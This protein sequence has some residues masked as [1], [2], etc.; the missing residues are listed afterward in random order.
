MPFDLTTRTLLEHYTANPPRT[1][2]VWYGPWISILTTLFPP[3][4]GYFV[5]P[6]RRVAEDSQVHIPDLLIEVAKISSPPLILRTVLIVKVRNSQHWE[7]G[8]DVL[9]R[10]IKLQ[11]DAA[12]F[13]TAVGKVY[14]I[15]TIGPHWRY[16]EKE[17][18]GQDPR[19]LIQWH[20][21]THNEA[22][23]RDLVDLSNLVADL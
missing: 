6:Q 4:Q 10:R 19:P 8:K 2:D 21:V 3:A 18:D 22:S 14:W 5:T 7:S 20:D 23:Y 11:T 12:F 16:G 15:G 9:M 1:E 13:G 17:D